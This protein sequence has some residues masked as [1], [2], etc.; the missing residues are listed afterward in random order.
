M[1]YLQYFDIFDEI[2]P[3]KRKLYKKRF[4]PFTLQD[5]EF[6]MKYRFSKVYMR[7]IV[8]LVQCDIELQASG[9]RLS[10]ELQV[11]L[12][13]ECGLGKKFK[14]MQQTFMDLANSPSRIYAE[15]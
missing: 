2:E 8:D 11:V 7:K 13:S 3:R 15:E 9:G 10:V 1:D 4:D 6:R 5:K 12:L 14:V